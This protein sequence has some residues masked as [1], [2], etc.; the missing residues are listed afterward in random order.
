VSWLFACDGEDGFSDVAVVGAA[1]AVRDDGEPCGLERGG[2]G[3]L[4]RPA[5][6]KPSWQTRDSLLP[7]PIV[8]LDLEV[9]RRRIAVANLLLP[10]N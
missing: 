7:L 6:S 1:H 4:S 9:G 5:R 8:D 2:C 10:R 3:R